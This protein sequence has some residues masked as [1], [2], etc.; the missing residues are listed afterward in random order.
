[1]NT[2]SHITSEKLALFNLQL[3]KNKKCPGPLMPTLHDAQHIFGYIPISI[4]KIIS[5]ELNESI[6]KINGVVTFYGN[7]SVVPKGKRTIG[8]CLGT[9]CYVRGSQTVMDTLEDEL[10]VKSG[11]TT[12]DGEFTLCA[13]RCIG[14]CG[15]A[16]VFSVDD[17]IYGNA[18]VTKAK[19]I[20]KEMKENEDEI[21]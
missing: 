9:A 13:T 11:E 8:V 21:I 6:A 1:M 10:K 3:E 12:K 18:S 14:A 19:Q 17:H 4:Q 7:F 2:N 15:L 5:K 16:P 20:L